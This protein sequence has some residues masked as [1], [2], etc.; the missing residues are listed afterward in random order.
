MA[1]ALAPLGLGLVPLVQDLCPEEIHGRN[2]NTYLLDRLLRKAWV[3]FQWLLRWL[4]HP[5][6]HV[7][8]LLKAFPGHLEEV[9]RM[10]VWGA[11]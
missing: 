5:I 6:C 7:K 8:P 10:E 2:I 3:D 4:R 11:P 9:L 1:W